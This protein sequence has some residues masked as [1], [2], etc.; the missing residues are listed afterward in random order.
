[1]ATEAEEQTKIER[2]YTVGLEKWEMSL[3]V[4][5]CSDLQKL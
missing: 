1:M 3:W 5:E 2:L 4:K